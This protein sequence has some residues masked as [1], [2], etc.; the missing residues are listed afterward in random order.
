LRIKFPNLGISI[1]PTM[2]ALAQQ[3]SAINLAQGFPGFSVD[4]VLIDLVYKYMR[5]G[6]NQYSPMAGVLKLREA[7]SVKQQKLHQLYYHP[8]TE[9]TICA[10]ATE[11]VFSVISAVINEGDEVI[12]FEPVFDIYPPAVLLNKGKLVRIK[13]K[14][15]HF[16]YDWEE[17]KS[18]INSKTKLIILNSPHNPT[19]KVLTQNDI[20]Q[21][22]YIIKDTNIIVLSD[23]VY[24]HI[25][26]DGK[27]HICLATHPELNHRTIIVASLGK[28]FHCTGWRIG[29]CLAPEKISTEIRKVHQFVTFSANTAIQYA[30]AEYL[31]SE[32]HYLELPVFFQQKRDF[33]ASRLSNSSF[34]LLPSEGSY[35]QLA[36]YSTISQLTDIEFAKMLTI[37]HG[38]AS[39][40]ISCF[41]EDGQDDKIIRFCF[42]KDT[43]ELEEA[44]SRLLDL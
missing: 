36:S 31:E 12:C 35:F 25:V 30:M 18:N 13:L 15:P 40:P 27:P 16:D 43:I 42:A 39:I 14:Q 38:V 3:H 4:Q 21:L 23:E 26:F 33:F 44:A 32:Q 2:S 1:F 5:N 10:G 29:Y 34:K 17:V 11:A 28:V 8:E 41:Y 7:L 24:E 19:G 9:I 37:E 22:A 6:Y 20:N